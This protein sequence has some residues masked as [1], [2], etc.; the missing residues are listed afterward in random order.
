MGNAD[1]KRKGKDSKKRGENRPE[2]EH[3][4]RYPEE[5]IIDALE[6]NDGKSK[7]AGSEFEEHFRAVTGRKE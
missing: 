5:E 2:P 3:Y 7:R 1:M 4:Q 6:E